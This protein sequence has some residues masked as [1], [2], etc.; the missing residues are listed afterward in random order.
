MDKELK[1]GSVLLLCIM[2]LLLVFAV[3]FCV[4]WVMEFYD[5][6]YST[7]NP[8]TGEALA[9]TFTYFF[10][11]IGFYIIEALIAIFGIILA[12][13]NR[14]IAQGRFV[15]VATK[16]FF[17]IFLLILLGIAALILISFLGSLF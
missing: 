8:T 16:I 2:L 10:Q 14:K 11:T 12:C 15:E 7:P 13:I 9:F 17:A 1:I 5:F 4:D 3:Y 6:K